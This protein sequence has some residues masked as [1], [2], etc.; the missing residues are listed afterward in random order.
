M[1]IR[2]ASCFQSVQVTEDDDKDLLVVA[3]IVMRVTKVSR[4]IFDAHLKSTGAIN[5]NPYR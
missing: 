1:V 4:K 5:D 3:Y 2:I